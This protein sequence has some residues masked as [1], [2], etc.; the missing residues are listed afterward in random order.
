M[1]DEQLQSLYNGLLQ[2]NLVSPKGSLEGFRDAYSTPESQRLLYD[3]LLEKKLVDPQGSFAGF[4]AA[5]FT[6]TDEVKKKEEG[7]PIG[8]GLDRQKGSETPAIPGV[9]GDVIRSV[10]YF[11]DFVDDIYRAA[12]NGV[13]RGEATTEVFKGAFGG[14]LTDDDLGDIT[15]SLKSINEAGVSDEAV[16]FQQEFESADNVFDQVY[17]MVANPTAMAEV[18]VGSIAQMVTTVTERGGLAAMGAGAAAAAPVGL[19][20]G[21]LAG[22]TVPAAALSGAV[23][24]L[25]GSVDATSSII[26][27][28]NEELR[29]QNL[30]V[31]KGNLRTVFQDRDAIDRMRNLALGRGIPIAVFDAM[32]MGVAGKVV[33][34]LGK[35]LKGVAAGAAVEMTG[36]GAGELSAQVVSGQPINTGDILLEA[37]AEGPMVMTSLIT[38][39]KG[40]YSI[41]GKRVSNTDIEGYIKSGEDLDNVQVKN[42]DKMQALLEDERENQVIARDLPEDMAEADRKRTIE[43]EREKKKLAGSNLSVNKRRVSDIDKELDEINDR[44]VGLKNFTPDLSLLDDVQRKAYE[45]ASSQTKSQVNLYL[46]EMQAEKEMGVRD[47]SAEEKASL[48]ESERKELE[49]EDALEE[50]YADDN[51]VIDSI[52]G[53]PR[54]EVDAEIFRFGSDVFDVSLAKEISSENKISTIQNKKLEA[55]LFPAIKTDQKTID[56]ADLSKPV[57]LVPYKDMGLRVIDGNHRIQ[58]AIQ[59][60]ESVKAVTLTEEQAKEIMN[61]TEVRKRSVRKKAV[62]EKETPT[63]ETKSAEEIRVELEK[64]QREALGGRSKPIFGFDFF[65]RLYDV[66]T[67]LGRFRKVVENALLAGGAMRKQLAPAVRSLVEDATNRISVEANQ[68]KRDLRQYKRLFPVDEKTSEA[69]N[70]YLS[71]NENAGKDFSDEQL[72]FLDGMRARIDGF[73]QRLIDEGLV[74]S[75]TVDL[76][77]ADGNE[78]PSSMADIIKANIGKYLRTTYESIENK[79]YVPDEIVRNKAKDKLLKDMDS[80]P[81]FQKAIQTRMDRDGLTRNEALEAQ[82]EDRIN[83]ILTNKERDFLGRPNIGKVDKSSLKRQKDI[84]AEIR[85]LMGEVKDPWYNYAKSIETVVQ[86]YYKE[87]MFADIAKTG[88]NLYFFREGQIPAGQQNMFTG[89]IPN[90]PGYGALAGM[91]TTPLIEAEIVGSVKSKRHPVALGYARVLSGAK[92]MKTIGSIPTHLLNFYGNIGFVIANGH[93]RLG[94]FSESLNT[95]FEDVKKMPNADRRALVDDLIARGV[96]RQSVTLGDVNTLLK[97]DDIGAAFDS[98]VHELTAKG[99]AKKLKKGFLT[100]KG[101]AE[102]VYQGTDDLFKI[103]GYLNE[104]NEYS[105][106]EYGKK[107]SELSVEELSKMQD[108]AASRTR[109]GY[110][111]YSQVYG[112]AKIASKSPLIAPFVSYTAESYRVSFN[113]FYFGYE[114]IQRGLKTGNAKLVAKGSQRLFLTAGVMSAKTAVQGMTGVATVA[115]VSG[116]F[117]EL[118]DSPEEKE[119]RKNITPFLEPWV[120]TKDGRVKGW[121]VPSDILVWKAEDGEIVYFNYSAK[122]AFGSPARAMNQ[123]FESAQGRGVQYTDSDMINTFIS[124]MKEVLS[125]FVTKDFLAKK[126]EEA[127]RNDGSRV[128]NETDSPVKQAYD[129]SVHMYKGIEP[130]TFSA[131]R[132]IDTSKSTSNAAATFFGVQAQRI[133]IRK[134]FGY[135]MYDYSDQIKKIRRRDATKEEKEKQIRAIYEDAAYIFKSAQK[136]GVS[137]YDLMEN[138]GGLS[139]KDL[140]SATVDNLHL[141]TI[142]E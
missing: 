18:M 25:S 21:P 71:G 90:D 63:E 80:D 31:S 36:A 113:L 6:P 83:S 37:A 137:Y 124:G 134:Q 116:L 121:T 13:H 107:P 67:P 51:E 41:N 112:L 56:N 118:Y 103:F 46:F 130:G 61:P 62:Q 128:Y 104:L 117:G 82:V 12:E 81:R 53:I 89:K 142:K 101:A 1:N 106:I 24:A 97:G 58:K 84:P 99:T 123:A 47:M 9:I 33:G 11:G 38:N 59:E 72:S 131:I 79:N 40:K 45:Q 8:I 30:E 85:A 50:S 55:L 98:R 2:Q 136:L 23:G 133:D 22:V 132:R 19:A 54:E 15:E 109:N 7:T 94:K 108:F 48:T 26:D 76:K 102:G 110:P 39:K 70:D 87:K 57:L 95:V 105:Q 139:K 66:K 52:L 44:Y 43:L 86:L 140:I 141:I 115:G 96:I 32:T 27:V 138:R 92:W 120:A 135:L 10:P 60:G 29:N 129:I 65:P 35:G 126:V 75:R 91:R 14:N 34:A 20:G 125:P 5:Y 111:D 69:A 49:L 68:L 100:A 77:D 114:D 73:S 78:V 119:K 64:N 4:Q 42:D 16:A 74:S 28:I 3:G 88:E 93:W 127:F 122:D 17:T